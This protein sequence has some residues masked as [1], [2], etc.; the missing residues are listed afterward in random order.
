MSVQCSSIYPKQ[1]WFAYRKENVTNIEQDQDQISHSSKVVPVRSNNQ[2]DSDEVVAQHLP[3]IL[4]ALL[5]VDD[6]DLLK[7]KSKL[8]QLIEL[9]QAPELTVGPVSP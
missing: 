4:A 5:D 6:E 7:P 1:V 8:S 9:G 2:C 3:V